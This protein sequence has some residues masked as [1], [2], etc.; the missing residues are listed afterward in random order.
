MMTA[1][2]VLVSL[3]AFAAMALGMARHA[4]DVL[5]HAP[6]PT[7]CTA[8]RAVGWVLLAVA[9][10]LGMAGWGHTV[11]VVEWTAALTA[12]ALPLAMLVLPRFAS[13][14]AATRRRQLAQA[15]LPDLSAPRGMPGRVWRWLRIAGLITLPMFLVWAFMQV[16]PNPV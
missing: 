4:K 7:L 2:L 14:A 15:E 6:S 1:A 3:A 8:L 16:P 9:L 11:G 13:G 12:V 10:A 5:G